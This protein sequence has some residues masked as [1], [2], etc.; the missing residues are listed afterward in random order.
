MW[1]KSPEVLPQQQSLP[2]ALSGENEME[3]NYQQIIRKLDNNI[4]YTVNTALGG[5]EEKENVYSRRKRKKVPLI[6]RRTGI[7]H[8]IAQC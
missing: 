7:L 3:N 5:G 8:N 6:A 4:I 1:V 2:P